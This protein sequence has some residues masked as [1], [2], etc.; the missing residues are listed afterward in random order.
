MNTALQPSAPSTSLPAHD[1]M[2]REEVRDLIR[3]SSVRLVDKLARKAGL[4][5]IR[6]SH[7]HTLYSRDAVL[8][9]LREH[10]VTGKALEVPKRRR[11]RPRKPSVML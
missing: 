8:A 9:W 10:Q 11:G 4:P 5:K 1:F 2:T 7:K 6:V 3:L